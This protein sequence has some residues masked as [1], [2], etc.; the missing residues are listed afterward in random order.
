MLV[1]VVVLL[2]VVFLFVVLLF[3]LLFVL[4]VVVVLVGVVF[5]LQDGALARVCV[6]GCHYG[7]DFSE[8]VPMHRGLAADICH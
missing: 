3:V 4:L 8:S 6:N 1:G 5:M 2:F 7:K